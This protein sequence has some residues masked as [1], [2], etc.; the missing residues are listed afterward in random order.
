[1]ES[2]PPVGV[3]FVP[4]LDTDGGRNF[5]KGIYPAPTVGFFNIDADYKIMWQLFDSIK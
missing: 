4:C 3:P 2:N 1:M 5:D